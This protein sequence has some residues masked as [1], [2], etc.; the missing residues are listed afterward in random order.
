MAEVFFNGPE[1]RIEA[2]FHAAADHRAPCALVLHPH[3]QYGGTM[4]NKVVYH[5]FHSFVEM[6]FSVLRFNFRGVGRSVGTYDN[7]IGE[8]ADAAC[9]M[10]WLQL[11]C[12]EARVFWVSGFS[13]G[14]WIA[15]Q[16]LMR[17]PEVQGFVAISP[18]VNKYDFSFLSPCPAPGIVIQGTADS[19]VLE[20]NVQRFL[21]RL[22]KQKSA[23][24]DYHTIEGADHFFR[25]KLDTMT[26]L[27]KN[28]L[29]ERLEGDSHA[30]PHKVEKRKRQTE[31]A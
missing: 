8:L 11:H 17:R 24:V 16:L 6:G 29:S 27:I 20:E 12:P 25:N 9:A 2:K 15:M 30:G 10:D 21:E 28:Y 1:G 22:G 18:P 13:F 14:A 7:G 4:N 3:P 31:A 26:E 23:V 19:V 5:T